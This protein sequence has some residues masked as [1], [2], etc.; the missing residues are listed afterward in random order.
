MAHS[1]L[2]EEAR[3]MS[4]FGGK[5]DTPLW[6]GWVGFGVAQPFDTSYP[7]QWTHRSSS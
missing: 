6:A 7:T 4:A 1:G 5:A 3:R 2:F